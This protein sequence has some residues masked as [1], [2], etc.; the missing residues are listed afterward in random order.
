[1]KSMKGFNKNIILIGMP[2]C[3]KSTIGRFLS[4]KTNMKYCDVDDYIEAKENKAIADI[5]KYGESYFRDIEEK[6]VKE[7]SSLEGYV[8]A[9]GGG[10]ILRKGNIDNLKKN[11]IIIFINRPLDEIALDVEISKRPLL[12]EGKD[13]LYKLYEDRYDLYKKYCDYEVF[14]CGTAV[15]ATDNI[16]NILEGEI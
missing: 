10:V 1:M 8:I 2:G 12:K 6:A 5:F 9:A 14:N 7:L 11:G 3:G 16:I 15:E 13:K 4:Q